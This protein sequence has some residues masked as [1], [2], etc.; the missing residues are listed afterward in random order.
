MSAED[1]KNMHEFSI[2]LSEDEI[3]IMIESALKARIN[4]RIDISIMPVL[5]AT[6]KSI[7]GEKFDQSGILEKEMSEFTKKKNRILDDASNDIRREV[8]NNLNSHI[9][10]KIKDLVSA[11]VTRQLNEMISKN[12]KNEVRNILMQEFNDTLKKSIESIFAKN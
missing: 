10:L 3:K 2:S 9:S 11:E 12:I 8:I 5:T 7:I 4:Q 1:K 6:T